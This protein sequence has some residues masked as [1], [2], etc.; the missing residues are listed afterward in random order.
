[1]DDVEEMPRSLPCSAPE[2]KVGLRTIVQLDLVDEGL[3]RNPGP[4][5]NFYREYTATPEPQTNEECLQ[6]AKDFAAKVAEGLKKYHAGRVLL[7][8]E[9]AVQH[10][11]LENDPDYWMSKAYRWR[12]FGTDC[13][14]ERRKRR[15]MERRGE[16]EEGY[17]DA[18]FLSPAQSL[19]P[20]PSGRVPSETTQR[21]NPFA[22]TSSGS[23]DINMH[24]SQPLARISQEP[25]EPSP[26]Y[27]RD[28]LP[29][30]P[31][32]RKRK[33]SEVEDQGQKSLGHTCQTKRQRRG[34]ATTHEKQEPVPDTKSTQGLRRSMRQLRNTKA[35][36]R[37]TRKVLSPL[38][39]PSDSS[40]TN[41]Q[42]HTSIRPP[43]KPTEMILST[44]YRKNSL[45]H[46]P[47]PS[48]SADST[49]NV[50]RRGKLSHTRSRE[51]ER[52]SLD[53]TNPRK[54]QRMGMPKALP[55][56]KTQSIPTPGDGPRKKTWKVAKARGGGAN[57]LKE[58]Q[59]S[60][61]LPWVLRPR[62]PISYCEV[63]TRAA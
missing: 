18:L 45:S 2:A 28:D 48:Y 35:H 54:R 40:G 44:S 1:M 12:E 27:N 20:P 63:G 60:R 39:P 52:R 34:I 33:H 61:V 43:K 36:S 6:E 25:L 50:K 53:K 62:N 59:A 22:A 51:D 42:N 15:K 5:E 14:V 30:L 3:K 21:S 17:A 13:F 58:L 16:A 46:Q 11:D 7:R 24:P 23:P 9:E 4:R 37:T 31:K 19:S 29:T 10:G 26:G 8:R 32:G 55:T 56:N 47:K 49:S 41:A 57:K 38:P